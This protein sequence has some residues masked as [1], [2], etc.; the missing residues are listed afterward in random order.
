MSDHSTL[1]FRDLMASVCTPVSV[2]TTIDGDRP[3]GTTVSAFT[4]LSMDPPMILVAL[5]RAS[6]L[7]AL[8]REHRML[9]LNILSSEQATLAAGFARKGDDKF[10]GVE[11][12]LR[13]GVPHITGAAGWL[14]GEVTDLVDGGDHV[15]ALVRVGE[16]AVGEGLPLTYHN[17]TFGTHSVLVDR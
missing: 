2:V 6:A 1:L 14:A 3:H 11:W 12:T 8:V 13:A 17:R 10:A 9:G 7:L 16:L 5:D 15:I 4:S